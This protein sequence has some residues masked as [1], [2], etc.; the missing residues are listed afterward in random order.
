[1]GGAKNE[2]LA[3]FA[4]DARTRRPSERRMVGNSRRRGKAKSADASVAG[5]VNLIIAGELRLA[6]ET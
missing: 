6:A 3:A 2:E 1:M 5:A 4:C